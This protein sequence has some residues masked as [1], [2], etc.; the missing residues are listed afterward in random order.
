MFAMAEMAAA[1][2]WP[3]NLKS[4]LKSFCRVTS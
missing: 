4:L 1:W 3:E 2:I